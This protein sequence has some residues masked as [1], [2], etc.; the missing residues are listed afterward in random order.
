MN[1][2]QI[3]ENC[4][5]EAAFGKLVTAMFGR[6]DEEPLRR[7]HH[8][9]TGFDEIT[10]RLNIDNLIHK[11]SLVCRA[12]KIPSKTKAKNKCNR[13]QLA[14]AK[15]KLKER[16]TMIRCRHLL[17]Q[18]QES[19]EVYFIETTSKRLRQFSRSSSKKMEK[20]VMVAVE[21]R[22]VRKGALFNDSKHLELKRLCLHSQRRYCLT[23][24]RYQV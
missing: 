4:N 8:I 19:A 15:H 11:S 10:R 12:G 1:T 24:E 20:R 14:A 13:K 18:M 21:R 7:W 16:N 22:T 23:P 17:V 3:T 2:V 6:K 5:H 9:K